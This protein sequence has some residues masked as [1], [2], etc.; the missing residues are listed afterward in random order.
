MIAIIDY[1]MGNIASVCNAFKYLGFDTCVTYDARK[2]RDATHLVLP[3][4][5]AAADAMAALKERGL[6]DAIYEHEITGKPFMGICLGMQLMFDRSYENGEHECLGVIP[7]CVVPFSDTAQNLRVPHMGWN[8]VNMRNS[9]VFDGLEQNTHMY[10]VHSY[11]AYGVPEHNII[12][13]TDYGTNFI[14]A[15]QKDNLIGLQFH[16]EK[17]GAQGLQILKN[18]GGI[19]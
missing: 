2:I 3:G 13:E 19:M 11:Y 7:G 17:S 6:N 12:G 9:R 5:G 10:F 8:N 16:P 14:S 18:F 4:V 15:V 1:G